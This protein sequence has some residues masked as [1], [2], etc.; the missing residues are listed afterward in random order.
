M[1][2][3]I[4]RR[5]VNTKIEGHSMARQSARTQADINILVK[6]GVIPPDPNQM[7]FGDFSNGDDFARIQNR[8]ASVHSTFDDLPSEI[9]A[10]FR[11]D[12]ANMLDFL[13]SEENHEEAI[14]LGLRVPNDVRETEKPRRR[15]KPVSDDS[16]LKK[17]DDKPDPDPK[18]GDDK[19][20]T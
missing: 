2:R 1:P 9:R 8:I 19:A 13:A 6:R 3:K 12:P 17:G 5:R 7:Q 11:N 20:D 16:E 18:K 10:K 15:K 4:N 14:K